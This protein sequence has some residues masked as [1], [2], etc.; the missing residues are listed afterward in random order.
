[1]LDPEALVAALRPALSGVTSAWIRYAHYRPGSTCVVGYRIQLAGVPTDLY[2]KAVAIDETAGTEPEPDASLATETP[3]AGRFALLGGAVTARLYPHDGKLKVLSHLADA[4]LRRRLLR[5]LVRDRPELWDAALGAMHYLPERRCVA[6]LLSGGS[7]VAALKAYAPNDYETA[8]RRASAFRSHAPL[9]VARCLAQSDRRRVLM[10]EW[11]PGRS[12]GEA[13][14]DHD[15]NTPALCSTGLALARLH[16]QEPT[17]LPCL[18]RR[19]EEAAFLANAADIRFLC[20]RLAGR[21]NRLVPRI[22]CGL[23]GGPRPERA[24]HGDFHAHQ[25][26]LADGGVAILDFDRARRGD[27]AADLGMFIAHLEHKAQR[28]ALP[29]RR[30]EHLAAAFLDGYRAATGAAEP[31]RLPLY[32]ATGL[33]RLAAHPLRHGEQDAAAHA[34]RLLVRAAAVLEVP[35]MAT[36]V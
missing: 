17:G 16:A 22:A 5:K 32:V 7:P 28:G 11:L 9:R 6:Q 13:V 21:L 10:F 34:E 15:A 8:R 26:I 14:C 33:V 23:R 36:R 31:A 3:V 1:V 25:V 20:P 19:E 27:P 30:V 12:L 29:A 4:T 24:T 2:A 18:T 35:A